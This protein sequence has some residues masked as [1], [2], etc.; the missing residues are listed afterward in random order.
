MT[1]SAF[2]L[3]SFCAGAVIL[4]ACSNP[5]TDGIP[6]CTDDLRFGLRVTV[7]DSLT[8]APP[9][10]AVLLARSGTVVD[11]VG[12]ATPQPVVQNGPPV[13]LLFAAGE[14]PGTYDLTVRSPGYRDWTRTGVQVTAD[15][16]H[17]LPVEITARLQP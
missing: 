9:A 10:S 14:R 6:V 13:L 5:L 15:E 16:C 17:V 8:N 12:P 1:S 4:S 2:R 3:A 7:V 11:S